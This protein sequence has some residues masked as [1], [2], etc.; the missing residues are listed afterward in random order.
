MGDNP[1]HR[2]HVR[3]WQVE[4]PDD[5]GRPVWIGSATYDERVGLSHTTG[6]ITHHIAANVDAERDHLFHCLEQTGDLAST[7]Q[8]PH[9]HHVLEGR[10][11]G[12]D[13]WYTDGALW[14]G[15]I[16]PDLP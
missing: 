6:E 5:D 16:A 11:G 9:F 13:R 12:G 3:F 2:H 15:R 7:Y 10:N 1:R 4:K 14:G 8:I